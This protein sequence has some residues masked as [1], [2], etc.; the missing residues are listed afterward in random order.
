MASLG[1]QQMWSLTARLRVVILVAA[2]AAGVVYVGRATP[3]ADAAATLSV[4]V[5][6]N[7]LLDGSGNP[8]RLVG[9]D[10]SGTEYACAQ[11]W[12]IFD[13]PSDAT[14][15]AAMAAWHTNAVRVPLNEDC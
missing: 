15:I 3:R 7:S 2:L 11:G 8:V 1:A 5:Q 10:R 4:K 12:G 9:V 13:G 6:G 14:S